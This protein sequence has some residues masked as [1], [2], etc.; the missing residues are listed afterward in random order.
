MEESKIHKANRRV[1]DASKLLE[2]IEFAA[3]VMREDPAPYADGKMAECICET[4]R[5][6]MEKLGEVQ[7]LLDDAE[8]DE[9]MGR[10]GATAP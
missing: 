2:I 3:N 6:A 10:T 8:K 5:I 1:F 7:K 9:A 4:A